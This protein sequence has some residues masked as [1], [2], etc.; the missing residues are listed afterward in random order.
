MPRLPLA[1]RR[2]SDDRDLS[3]G[4]TGITPESDRGPSRGVRAEPH[5]ERK[6][7]QETQESV[8]N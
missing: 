1:A 6:T 8:Q 7:M 2:R 3:S 4:P 5:P